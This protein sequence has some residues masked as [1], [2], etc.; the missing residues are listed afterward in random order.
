MIVLYQSK[1]Y[2]VDLE[3]EEEIEEILEKFQA[4]WVSWIKKKMNE[5]IK[6]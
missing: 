1:I 4:V 5:W 2:F 6:M 3:M